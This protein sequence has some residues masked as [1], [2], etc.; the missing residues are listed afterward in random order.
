MSGFETVD[1]VFC[2]I[3]DKVNLLGQD[4]VLPEERNV[5]FA[6]AALGLI[7]NGS[8][9]YFFENRMKAEDTAHAFEELGLDSLAECFRLAAS[10]LPSNFNN[11]DNEQQREFLTQFEEALDQ[12]AMKI[13][14]E[15]NK[16]ESKIVEY[17][18]ERKSLLAHLNT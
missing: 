11:L 1:Q 7:E 10:L 4:A 14:E 5:Y 15:G 17:I 16:G 13:V 18:S 9:N 8:F 6:W 3:S 12:L 2:S